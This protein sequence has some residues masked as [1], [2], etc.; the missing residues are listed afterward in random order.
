MVATAVFVKNVSCECV[1]HDFVSVPSS[2]YCIISKLYCIDKSSY[3]MSEHPFS[4]QVEMQ[5][6]LNMGVPPSKIVYANPCKQASHL[7]YALSFMFREKDV[8]Q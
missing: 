2:M 6:M 5:T 4:W 1:W 7:R 3:L 8:Y